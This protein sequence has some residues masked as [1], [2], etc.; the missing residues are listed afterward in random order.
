LQQKKQVI[1]KTIFTIMALLAA[2][3]PKANAQSPTSSSTANEG[4]ALLMVHFGTTHDDT[5][6]LTIDA[7]NQLAQQQFPQMEM[8]EAYT[9]R[10]VVKRLAQRGIVKKTP[11]EMLLQLR[12]EGYQHIIVQTTHIIPGEE[13]E[14]LLNDVRQVEHLFANIHVGK[15][16]LYSIE[17][18][19]K[20]AKVFFDIASPYLQA[21]KQTHVVLVGHG[22]EHPT[23]AI[24]SQMDAMLKDLNPRIHVGTIEGYPD[25]D[26]V[27]ENL[28]QA[29]ARRVILMPFMFVA[30][31]HAK[32]DISIEWK[33]ALEKEGIQ[34]ELRLEGLGQNP[35]I[36]S[37]FMEHILSSSQL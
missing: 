16:L 34:V 21:S 31:D 36:Q 13:Y 14:T 4:T 9:S 17:D 25:F 23:N 15:P 28:K 3:V 30:G 20:V 26:R 5:R 19:R 10:I 11:L 1:M 18:C 33:D 35:Q 8:R 12:S 7:V 22:T 2:L 29:K 37:L 32:N 27:L 24:Y 6:Q